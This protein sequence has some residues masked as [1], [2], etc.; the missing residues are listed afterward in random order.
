MQSN[1]PPTHEK[2]LSEQTF[3][4]YTTR[5]LDLLCKKKKCTGVKNYYFPK[6]Q[7]LIFCLMF[8]AKDVTCLHV[9]GFLPT[10]SQTKSP[11]FVLI[12]GLSRHD[13]SPPAFWAAFE[14]GQKERPEIRGWV[15]GVRVDIKSSSSLQDCRRRELGDEGHGCSRADALGMSG[16]EQWCPCDVHG[17]SGDS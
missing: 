17:G 8:H 7:K 13:I 6:T 9:R 14:K 3:I 5:G 16:A 15:L 1:E 2:M 11:L 12:R 4:P 10:A